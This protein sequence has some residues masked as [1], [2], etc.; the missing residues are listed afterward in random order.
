M[1]AS[2]SPAMQAGS[3]THRVLSLIC[4]VLLFAMMFVTI[5]DVIGRYLFNTPLQGAT[6][7]TALLLVSTIFIGLPA[8]CLDEENVSVD[9]VVDYLP[10]WVQPL[11]RRFVRLLSAL[12]L[13]VVSWRLALH[14]Q[15]LASYHETTVSLHLPVAPFAWGCA[16]ATFVAGAITLRHAIIRR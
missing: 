2:P 9:L 12:V 11:R 4:G 15:A 7:L 3:R 16:A 13:G 14:A 6:E 5:I 1:S 8:V 10:D